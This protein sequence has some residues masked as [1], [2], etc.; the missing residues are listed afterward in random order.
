M[1]I[2][3]ALKRTASRKA[4]VVAVREIDGME[5]VEDEYGEVYYLGGRFCSHCKP[6]DRGVLEYKSGLSMGGWFFRKE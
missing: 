3:E 6:G 2:R 5:T 1:T 4:V